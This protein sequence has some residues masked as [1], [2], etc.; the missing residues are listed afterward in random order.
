[1]Q[2][3]CS[4]QSWSLAQVG[5]HHPSGEHFPAGTTRVLLAPA[6][7]IVVA[8]RTER[9]SVEIGNG[10]L[11]ASAAEGNDSYQTY[12]P[13]RLLHIRALPGLNTSSLT[14]ISGRWKVVNRV[15]A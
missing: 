10:T 5:L 3:N 15:T 4:G 2:K 8:H 14:G 1:M 6:I 9:N 7:R 11:I 13:K 12:K